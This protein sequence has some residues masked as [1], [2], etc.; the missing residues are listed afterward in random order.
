M[1]RKIKNKSGFGL[2]EIIVG[3]SIVSVSL[4]GI[5]LIFQ[6]SS[7]IMQKSAKNIRVAFL[8]EEGV[9]A[10]RLMRDSSWEDNIDSLAPPVNYY[11]N[12]RENNW[13]LSSEN[14]YIDDFFERKFT[15]ENVYRD[16]NDNIAESG[17][18]D[19]NTKKINVYVSWQEKNST[20]TKNISFYLTNIFD[21]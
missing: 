13:H 12:F 5:F 18:I 11:F 17:I 15:V 9:E 7:S 3:I 6:F 21:N 4:F 19:P 1:K 8:L 2:V 20:T 10:V 16:I 14:V